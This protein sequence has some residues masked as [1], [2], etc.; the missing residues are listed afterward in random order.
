ML[1]RQGQ[2][3][4]NALLQMYSLTERDASLRST[5]LP[6]RLSPQGLKSLRQKTPLLRFAQNDLAGYGAAFVVGLHHYGR[7]RQRGFLDLDRD[8][9]AACRIGDGLGIERRGVG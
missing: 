9:R 6:R 3:E 2:V 5:G 1:F 8:R 4:G 7:I